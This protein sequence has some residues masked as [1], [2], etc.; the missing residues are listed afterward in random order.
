MHECRSR[1]ARQVIESGLNIAIHLDDRRQDLSI[2]S[3]ATPVNQIGTHLDFVNQ[4]SLGGGKGQREDA[5]VDGDLGQQT[6]G[7]LQG[8]QT[9]GVFEQIRNPVTSG[10]RRIAH[11]GGVGQL[12]GG[13]IILE[14]GQM[15]VRNTNHE[16]DRNRRGCSRVVGK[17]GLILVA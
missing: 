9:Q 4:I 1:V 12:V 11:Y 16:R 7:V 2:R 14:P 6:L 17:E 8:R 3:F 13:E 10:R 5:V 15:F